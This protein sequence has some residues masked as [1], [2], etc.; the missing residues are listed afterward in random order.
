MDGGGEPGI[1]AL[2]SQETETDPPGSNA[3]VLRS[4]LS[5]QA[6]NPGEKATPTALSGL[7]ERNPDGAK[8]GMF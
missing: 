3:M 6:P 4:P 2:V 8:T 7:R 1:R 5:H